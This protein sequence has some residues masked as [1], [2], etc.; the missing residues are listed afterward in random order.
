MEYK[1]EFKVSDFTEVR[2]TVASHKEIWEWA[3][4]R[5]PYEPSDL[6]NV[7]RTKGLFPRL[8]IE[9]GR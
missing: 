8:D 5:R 1:K 6:I 9:K 2:P 3:N 7:C 4:E